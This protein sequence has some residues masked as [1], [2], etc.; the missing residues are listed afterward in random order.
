[1]L[2]FSLFLKVGTL[3]TWKL[4]QDYIAKNLCVNVDKPM[5]GCKGK[6]QLDK[7][8]M[9][10]DAASSQEKSPIQETLKISVI[11]LFID[12]NPF[13]WSGFHPITSQPVFT[14]LI[15]NHYSFAYL[16]AHLKPP[17]SLV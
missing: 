12:T 11:D 15:A 17:I 4:N 8:L 14:T 5:M 10:I 13:V 9:K 6:C 16:F 2:C 1:M 3:I 7:R